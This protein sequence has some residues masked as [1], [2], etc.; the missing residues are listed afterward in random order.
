[1]SNRRP[2]TA[3]DRGAPQAS[4]PQL[5]PVVR[6]IIGV[7]IAS[8]VLDVLTEQA[9]RASPIFRWLAL[10]PS[11]VAHGEVWRL[12][13][14]VVAPAGSVG[15]IG[16]IF[17]LIWIWQFGSPIERAIGSRRF[18]LFATGLV[19]VPSLFAVIIDSFHPNNF[20]SPSG[21]TITLAEALAL[22]WVAW[23]PDGIVALLPPRFAGRYTPYIKVRSF[24]LAIA[25]M[26]VIF[27]LIR[28]QSQ[29][30]ALS[31]LSVATGWL[32]AQNWWRIDRILD[33]RASD[34]TK[35]ERGLSKPRP[36][37][38]LRVI[39]GGL[40]PDAPKDKSLLN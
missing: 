39:R 28:S 2:I 13:T 8:T 17:S 23:F 18:A 36:S 26:A 34:R 20:T 31:I 27:A 40:D 14:Y 5:T 32:L 33:R 22:A 24:G 16:L 15:L 4:Y 11:R 3:D 35:R 38:R 29:S 12:L 30:P 19:V 21:G 1:M 25:A 6:A 7:V 9:G 37:H 10:Y